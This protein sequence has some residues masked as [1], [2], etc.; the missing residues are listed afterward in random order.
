M[1]EK[2]CS[3]IL[4]L[5]LTL[6]AS[7]QTTITGTVKDS[8]NKPVP[9]ASVYLSRTTFGSMTDNDGAFRFS[10]PASGQY[11][12]TASCV[13]YKSASVIINSDGRNRNINF[14][15]SLNTIG[16]DEITVRSK[17]P[18]RQR[19]YLQFVKLFIGETE[20]SEGCKIVNP[21]D[22]HLYS[23]PGDNYLKGYSLKPLTIVNKNLGYTILYDLGDFYYDMK[24]GT[25]RFSGT[26]YFQPLQGSARKI[27][28]W[29]KNRLLAYYGSRMNLLRAISSD[30]LHQNGFQIFVSR[31]DSV[32]KEMTAVKPL[33]VN[34]IRLH[35]TKNYSPLYYG[36]QIFI[37]YTYDHPEL[38][39]GLTGFTKRKFVSTMVLHDTVNVYPYGYF[40][41]PYSIT[42]GGTMATERVS[43]M[44]PYD[45]LRNGI[46]AS[47]PDSGTFQSQVE[48]YLSRNQKGN[49][50]DQ[51]FVQ[52]DRNMYKPGD[53]I[54]FQAYIRDRFTGFFESGSNSLYMLLFNDKHV[55][56][57]SS[58]FKLENSL[59]PGWMVI[60][61]SAEPGRYQLI[62]FTD[63][64]QDFDPENAFQLDL[65]VRKKE[66]P[67]I[68]IYSKF[69]K[70][71]YR[72]GDTLVVNIKITGKNDELLRSQKFQCSLITGPDKSTS[73]QGLTAK[74]GE[75][76]LDFIIPDTVSARPGIQIATRSSGSKEAIIKD[77]NFPFEDQYSDLRFLPEGGTFIEGLEQRVGFNSTN[78]RGQ[79]LSFRGVLKNALGQTLDSIKSGQYGPGIFTCTAASGMYVEEK[80]AS[81]KIRKWPLPEPDKNGLALSTKALNP[82]A[83]YIEIQESRY[84]GE[85]VYVAGSMN[86]NLIFTHEL[87]LDKKQRMA[88]STK[89]LPAGVVQ[90]TLF[91]K[92]RKPV[93]ER[94]FY[95]NPDKHLKFTVK[96]DKPYYSPGNETEVSVSAVD[97]DG[98]PVKGYF[99]IAAID[100]LSGYNPEI[101]VPGME[102]SNNYHPSLAANLPAS[103]LVKGLENLKN[104]DVDLLF[105]VY[106]WSRYN[107]NFSQNSVSLPSPDNY[108]VLKMKILY[109]S[110][111]SKSDRKLD[112]VSLEGPSI[113]HLVTDS[114]GEITLPLDS[115]PQITRSVTLM[116][117]VQNKKRI[118]GA[119]LSIPYNEKY[120]RSTKL[121]RIQP[122][123]P[124][125]IF[126]ITPSKI[127]YSLGDSVIEI[128]EVIIK[129]TPRPEKV[130]HDIYE[131]KYQYTWVESL[132]YEQLWTSANFDDAVRR[133]TFC[134]I[135]VDNIYLRAK[136][137]MFGGN[138]PVFIILDGMP[139]YYD[140]YNQVKSISPSQLTSLTVLKSKD[141]F[142]QYGEVALGGILFVNTRTND[143]NLQKYRTEWK[144]QHTSD[145]MLLPINLY[146]ANKE[147]Y[148]PTKIEVETD[149]V[150][151]SYSTTYWNP[152]VYLDGEKPAVIKFKNL[153]RSG[154]VKI[155]INGFSTAD[156]M[157]TGSASYMVY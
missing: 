149:P 46:S 45:F 84:N 139:L 115:L 124:S 105:M 101:F 56:A 67:N 151:H 78:S 32:T 61:A 100:S 103:A 123:I 96:T 55:L 69:D 106:G 25:L 71:S 154:P 81:G 86:S 126:K 127:N 47:A 121:F 41:D 89:E 80:N 146:R 90:I 18:N 21:E 12:L 17:D 19:N 92:D 83:F 28:I 98:L 114:N 102:Y 44:I 128:P 116:P 59:A 2:T 11:E 156:L 40:D 150:F 76:V 20:N 30:S 85:K 97:G 39:G 130:Y 120:F 7:A 60:P 6:A 8:L 15:L 54:H 95:V 77:F 74:N 147:F 122:E 23:D 152:E 37:T 43:E 5:F 4:F 138:R 132:D 112:L 141:G 134:D 66:S 131:E 99:S 88:V 104:E 1:K 113:K 10:V 94:L 24:A 136:T 62:S 22:V 34:D 143:K 50:A 145:R 148:T 49:T 27:R 140:G 82:R 64:M 111:S 36:S 135:T 52:T 157:G 9:G 133:L 87:T 129:G 26:N 72:P 65:S 73:R 109:A 70:E 107:W 63:R 33:L 93:A 48:K 29:E 57:D 142:Y 153:P 118:Q 119:M 3:L 125:E 14:R 53:T 51:V 38:E 68:K 110:G 13:G 16:L 31:I 79:S 75:T 155:T 58:R 91:N 137:S 35:G 144:M 42:W 108:D 117:D